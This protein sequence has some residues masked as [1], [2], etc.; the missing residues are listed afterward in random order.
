M[1]KNNSLGPVGNNV[2]ANLRRLRE[3][4]GWTYQELSKRLGE[5]GRPIPTLG[6]SRVEKGTRR[7]DADDLV[8]LA[9]I[10]NVSPL[11]LLLP[12]T[13]TEDTTCEVLNGKPVTTARAWLWAEG[14]VPLQGEL[15]ERAI[16]EF[17]LRSQPHGRALND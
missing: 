11:A 6:L 8:A 15:E 14:K 17:Q 5:V 3:G 9:A 4:R 2:R 10:L 7:V 1:A 16:L 13:A 12:P